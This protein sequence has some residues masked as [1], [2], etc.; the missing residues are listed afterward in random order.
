MEGAQLQPLD[1]L[2]RK[3]GQGSRHEARTSCQDPSAAWDLLGLD[4][5]SEVFMVG[6]LPEQAEGRSPA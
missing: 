6:D 2:K 5:S 4:W 3:H 1:E